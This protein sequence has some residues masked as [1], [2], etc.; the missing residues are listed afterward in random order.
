MNDCGTKKISLGGPLCK[1][2]IHGGVMRKISHNTY[3]K[4]CL[5]KF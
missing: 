5:F 2:E 3:L 1:K 4:S